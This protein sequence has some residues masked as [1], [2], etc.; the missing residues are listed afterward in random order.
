MALQ[1]FVGPWPLFQFLDPTHSRQD[2]LDGGSARRK[3][4]TYTDINTNRTKAHNA[5]IHTW[6]T[7][8]TRDPSVRASEDS[9]YLR[10]R[11]HCD[12]HFR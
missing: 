9:S 3:A 2:T 4:A 7:I 8:K 5:D 1:S 6:S 10:Q 12:P 11:G